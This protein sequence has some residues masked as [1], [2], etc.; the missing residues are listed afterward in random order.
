MFALL[1]GALFGPRLNSGL[2]SRAPVKG[3]KD[4][5]YV[6]GGELT[7]VVLVLCG[8]PQPFFFSDAQA[9]QEER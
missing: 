4:G 5:K 8:L 7:G 9:P 3:S 2:L 1:K 6:G